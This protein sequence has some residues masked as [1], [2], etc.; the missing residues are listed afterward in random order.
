M[1]DTQPAARE[2]NGKQQQQPKKKKGGT[3][4][5][6]AVRGKPLVIG[7][8]PAAHG[9]LPKRSIQNSLEQASAVDLPS[10]A[11]PLPLVTVCGCGA[12]APNRSRCEHD[13][14]LAERC[15]HPLLPFLLP[16]PLCRAHALLATS[17]KGPMRSNLDCRAQELTRL[18]A[19]EPRGAVGD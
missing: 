8:S 16:S 11:V 3:G 15:A 7:L 19:P 9:R 17:L 18:V 14:G 6:V 4:N 1:A 13:D 5:G 2:A 12:P 10:V